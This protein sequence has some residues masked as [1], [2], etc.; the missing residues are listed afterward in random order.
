M[1]AEAPSSRSRS[2]ATRERLIEAAV[3]AFAQKGFAAT[4]T[5]DIASRAGMSPAAVYVHH[6]TK[7]ELL[8]EVSHR[9]H[10]AALARI[11]EAAA[12]RTD[13]V[14]RIGHMVSEFSRWHAVNS[15]VG[16]IVQY[17]FHALTPEHRREIAEYRRGI[18]REMQNALAEGV[19]AGVVDA[20]DLKGTALALLSISIDLVRWYSPDGP[21]TPDQMA[22]LH[23]RLAIRMVARR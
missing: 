5:R 20:E 13:P 15:R 11:R 8:F 6:A 23:A 17:E 4:T 9:G 16:R 18:E 10:L 19:A 2:A 12:A 1:T 14:E 7:E 21:T 22:E 3:E